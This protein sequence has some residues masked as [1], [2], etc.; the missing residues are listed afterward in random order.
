MTWVNGYIRLCDSS[1]YHVPYWVGSDTHSRGTGNQI[2]KQERGFRLDCARRMIGIYIH[3]SENV[4][5][6]VIASSSRNGLFLVFP[7]PF[8]RQG[9]RQPPF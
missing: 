1:S 8:T 9:P 7:L 5:N 6:A 4:S 2:L 3:G